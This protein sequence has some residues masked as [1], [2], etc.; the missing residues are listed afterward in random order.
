MSETPAPEESDA[1]DTDA[2]G[3]LLT[4]M[5]KAAA[6]ER[7]G[8]PAYR[9]MESAGTV[10]Q[11]VRR[12]E[13][14]T[15][16][17]ILDACDVLTDKFG[18]ED[19]RPLY[20]YLFEIPMRFRLY[21]EA[22]RAETHV[23]CV[24]RAVEKIAGEIETAGNPAEAKSEPRYAKAGLAGDGSG[25]S[26]GPV[27]AADALILADL[28]DDSRRIQR[29]SCD[30][31]AIAQR[32]LDSG[33]GVDPDKLAGTVRLILSTAVDIAREKDGLETR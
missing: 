4:A 26:I 3:S 19:K 12:L 20:D 23:G 21:R 28:F 9:A 8:S 31:R 17:A 2:L 1:L 6:D 14:Q 15:T 29:M 11:L 22:F 33:A 32:I 18:L 10:S 16:T 5:S 13:H 27:T 30:T 24:D 7:T 25:G